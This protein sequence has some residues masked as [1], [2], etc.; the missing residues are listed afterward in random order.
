[1]NIVGVTSCSTGIAQT[2]IAKERLEQNAR[3]RGH[4]IK[5][6]TQGTM[7]LES[8]LTPEDIRKADL[9]VISVAVTIPVSY[10]QLVDFGPE[11]FVINIAC[12]TEQNQFYRRTSVSYTHLYVRL[13]QPSYG[14][15]YSV[16]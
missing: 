7:G 16:Y 13:C 12:E 9:V 14:R 10:T 8:P 2:Y 4:N 6:E 5:I 15:E 1:M 3:R 11:P